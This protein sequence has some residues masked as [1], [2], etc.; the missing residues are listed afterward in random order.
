[1]TCMHLPPYLNAFASVFM[2]LGVDAIVVGLCNDGGVGGE[3]DHN[4]IVVMQESEAF[5]GPTAVV[6]V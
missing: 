3:T 2:E 5:V 6:A 4:D 1:M